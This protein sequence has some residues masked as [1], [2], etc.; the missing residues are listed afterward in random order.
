MNEVKSLETSYLDYK[1]IQQKITQE[2]TI[3]PESIQID[4]EGACNHR[5]T[6]CSYRRAGWRDMEYFKSSWFDGKNE[7]VVPGKSG[8]SKEVALSLCESI[9]NLG[10]PNT[11]IT[12]GGE[13]LIYPFINEMLSALKDTNTKVSLVTNG[14]NLKRITPYIGNNFNWIRLS[15]N[16][17]TA[18]TH[19]KV[20]GAGNYNHIMKDFLELRK[21]HPNLPIYVSYCVI[22]EN[23]DEIIEATRKYKTLGFSGIKFN[24]V[25]TPKG[26]GLF[27]NDEA[28]DVLQ[29]IKLAKIYEGNS[30]IV[31]NSFWKREQY[32]ENDEFTVCHFDK[33][34]IAVGYNGLVYPCCIVKNRTGFEYGDLNIESL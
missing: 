30:F 4:P 18:Q 3:I 13:P 24:A 5:C 31:K 16:A 19:K 15:L 20:N 25:F 33:F 22:P 10:I 17:A 14:T 29:K 28:K 9:N 8:L 21:Q 1:K 11:C 23:V 2:T 32:G 34:V 12:G 6:F 7:K 26:D 27:N